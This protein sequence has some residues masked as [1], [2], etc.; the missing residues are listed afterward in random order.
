MAVRWQYPECMS[1][2]GIRIVHE[3]EARRIDEKEQQS[4]G[5]LP[6]EAREPAHVRVNKTTGTGLEI[7][8]KDGHKSNWTFAWLRDA[9]PCATCYQEREQSGRQPGEPK[10]QPAVLLPMYQAPAQPGKVA[11]VGRYAISFDWSDGHT[12]GIYS[13]EYLRSH[14]Q[15]EQCRAGHA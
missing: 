1:H 14:C 4:G 10:A 5:S 9:C 11:P 8:W 12:S 2:E 15:C 13:W 6:R 3:D 7:D